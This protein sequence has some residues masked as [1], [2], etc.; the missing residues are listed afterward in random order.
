MTRDVRLQV[1]LTDEELAVIKRAADRLGLAA[2]TYMRQMAL[3]A[4]RKDGE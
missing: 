2:S 4:A 3:T 1:L